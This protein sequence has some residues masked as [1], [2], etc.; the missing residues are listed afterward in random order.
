MRVLFLSLAGFAGSMAFGWWAFPE[1]LYRQEPQPLQ[2]N[3]KIH[4]GKGSMEC[5]AC[6][7]STG[8]GQFAGIPQI[9][10]CAA[11]H[12]EAIGTTENEKRLVKEFV[13]ANREIG[14]K[15]YS[16]QPMNV[17]FSHAVHVK[18]GELKCP[19]CH[20]DR[21]KRETAEPFYTNRITGESRNIWG[22]SM[23]RA[24]LKAGDGMKMS[25]CET[26]HAQ[27]GVPAGCLGCHR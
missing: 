6:H 22:P 18:K 21:G 24:D 15:V 4:I 5:E 20:G 27:R 13:A 9:S 2:F 8:D 19:V 10:N 26:C 7:E 3:H 11:C 17:R 12:T 14:W 23:V 16:R 25:D 1:A